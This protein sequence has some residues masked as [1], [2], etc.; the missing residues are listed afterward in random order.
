MD[1]IAQYQALFARHYGEGRLTV[2]KVVKQGEIVGYNVN[3]DG[4]GSAFMSMKD[5]E[6]ANKQF[7]L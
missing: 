5:I 3:I 6:E 4:G 1:T 7:S 2:R